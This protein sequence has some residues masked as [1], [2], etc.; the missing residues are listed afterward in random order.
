[1]HSDAGNS[2]HRYSH[3]LLETLNTPWPWPRLLNPQ[4]KHLIASD[5]LRDLSGHASFFQ[6]ALGGDM[7]LERVCLDSA[8]LAALAY[9]TASQEQ[10]RTAH[11]L[12]LLVFLLDD[13]SDRLSVEET[14]KFVGQVVDA[15]RSSSTYPMVNHDWETC[16]LAL[17]A[18][19]FASLIQHSRCPLSARKHII[20]GVCAYVQSL[21]PEAEY[22]HR[23]LSSAA[24]ESLAMETYLTRRFANIG[25]EAHF[26]MGELVLNIELPE[27]NESGEAFVAYDNPLLVGMRTVVGRM[28]VLSNDL[29]SYAKEMRQGERGTTYNGLS[30]LASASSEQ[31]LSF[32]DAEKVL[33]RMYQSL[34][35]EFME[36]HGQ[37]CDSFPET[38]SNR[39]AHAYVEHLAHWPR[40]HEFFNLESGRYGYAGV[41]LD[42]GI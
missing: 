32:E 15:L 1:M 24:T 22:R 2:L 6:D 17:C 28:F 42:D 9:P 10:L 3:C 13:H 39:D 12:T 30:L 19:R 26:A 34:A 41:G 20:D 33:V 8:L 25:A 36:L 23:D 5:T 40:A 37:F 7:K 14:K 4:Y 27:G 38:S 35:G 31:P 18:Q 21:L 29:V 16:K 11:A